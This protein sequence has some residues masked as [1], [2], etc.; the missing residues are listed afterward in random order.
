MKDPNWTYYYHPRLPDFPK[1][2][3][4]KTTL[5]SKKKSAST[6]NIDT[7]CSGRFYFNLCLD[8]SIECNTFRIN[9]IMMLPLFNHTFIILLLYCV[10]D[11][12]L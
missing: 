9:I 8:R 10:F 11:L 6:V 7:Y 3:E 1:D 12:C 5:I 2:R 4:I